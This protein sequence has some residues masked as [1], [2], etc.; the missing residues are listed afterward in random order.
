MAIRQY[1]LS[2]YDVIKS[3]IM[4]VMIS[5]PQNLIWPIRPYNMSL[6]DLKLFRPM[7]TELFAKEVRGF[8]ILFYGKMAV[9]YNKC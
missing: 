7:K 5:L 2:E 1:W 8:A 3:M 4:K 6:P 9:S